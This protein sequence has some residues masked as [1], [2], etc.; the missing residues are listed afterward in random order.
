[1]AIAPQIPVERNVSVEGLV[2]ISPSLVVLPHVPLA[3]EHHNPLETVY[4]I[5]EAMD[6]AY[7]GP[8]VEKL[9]P[10]GLK[11]ADTIFER[12]AVQRSENLIA[13]AATDTYGE[14]LRFQGSVAIIGPEEGMVNLIMR[15]MP[16]TVRTQQLGP[17]AFRIMNSAKPYVVCASTVESSS[18]FWVIGQTNAYLGRLP[19]RQVANPTTVGWH[20]QV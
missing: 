9:I 11:L 1:M 3:G 19:A 7:L 13:V 15:E 16:R 5:A 8:I 2:L 10:R 6:N 17:G 14:R 20:L 18:H 4:P 12:V